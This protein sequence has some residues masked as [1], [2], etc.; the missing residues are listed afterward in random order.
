MGRYEQRKGARGE[1]LW[2][3]E[4]HKHG[5]FG[6]KRMGQAMYQRGA[7]Q[8]DCIGLPHLHQ[9]VKFVEHLNYR[10]AFSQAV[11]DCRMGEKPMLA[12]KVSRGEWLVTMRSKDFF[13]FYLAW[14]MK[15]TCS[16]RR[17]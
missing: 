11:R 6:V 10:K 8:A 17:V 1:Y 13:E 12:S 15:Y 4:C 7:E 16:K 5:F 3:D 9:E 2:R 14:L